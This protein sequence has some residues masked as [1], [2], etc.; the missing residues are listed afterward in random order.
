MYFRLAFRNILRQRTRSAVTLIAIAFGIVALV[1]SGGFIADIFVQLGEAI[2]HSQ[3]GHI[4][5]SRKGYRT[6]GARNPIDYMFAPEQRLIDAIGNTPGVAQVGRRVSFQGL[7][8]NG[9]RDLPVV[10]EGIE[11]TVES[12]IGS[13]IRIT[14]G[15]D[16]RDDDSFGILLGDGLAS[17]L[18]LEIGDSA[19]IMV[20]A[21]GGAVNVLDF[22]VIG[23][24]QSF[25]KEFD[26]RAV[27]I[28]LGDAQELLYEQGINTIVVGLADTK[29]TGTATAAVQA[30]LAGTD[31]E[32]LDW[33]ELSDFYGKTVALYER[34]F[35]VLQA[36]VLFMVILSVA[37]SVNMSLYERLGE[38][39]TMLAI[40]NRRRDLFNLMLAESVVLGI[41]GACLGALLGISLAFLISSIGILMPPPP[42][43]NVGYTAK[44]IVTPTNV[45]SAMGIGFLATVLATVLPA[46]RVAGTQ[47]VDALRQAV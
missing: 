29:L 4:Q 45:L 16:L 19:S 15:R 12:E 20:N 42:S 26:A 41:V 10:G 21:V 46:K 6:D 38:F 35:F 34:Q 32:A 44:I 43:A 7:I 14:A 13:Q 17:T 9:K 47:V 27:R 25:S 30:L 18:G 39:G 8:G 33:Q 22:K 24:F 5:V 28:G 23:N 3:T 40:G 31:L 36:I 11:P 1:L 2:V 37:N